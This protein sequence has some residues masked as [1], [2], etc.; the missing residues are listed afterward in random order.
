L[1]TGSV[2]IPIS[3]ETA[4]G[5]GVNQ[6]LSNKVDF[7]SVNANT[8]LKNRLVTQTLSERII[9]LWKLF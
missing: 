3:P 9:A 8:R 1:A 5:N 6:A 7:W 2:L 4:A